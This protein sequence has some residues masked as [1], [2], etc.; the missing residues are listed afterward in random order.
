MGRHRSA[1]SS[2][3]SRRASIVSFRK[4]NLGDK[5]QRLARLSPS[6]VR[7]VEWLVDLMLRRLKE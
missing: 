6:R 4:P 7:A 5:L 3:S 1:S 2:R